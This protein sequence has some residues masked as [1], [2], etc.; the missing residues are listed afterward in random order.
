MKGVCEQSTRSKIEKKSVLIADNQTIIRE[1]IKYRIEKDQDFKIVGESASDRNV[2]EQV[3]Q[4]LPDILIFDF[5]E[6]LINGLRTIRQLKDHFNKVKI[7]VYTNIIDPNPVVKSLK[8]GTDGYVL[9]KSD[10]SVLIKGIHTILEGNSFID[11]SL[12]PLIISV[13][14]SFPTGKVIDD[15]KYNQLTE[16]ETE[17]FELVT[18]GKK[19]REI[20]ERLYISLKTVET[21]RYNIF[22][23]LSLS[24]VHELIDYAEKIGFDFYD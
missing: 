14:K 7:L 17:V 9:K 16:R 1:G 11:Y 2:I 24:T 18:K 20:A 4:T 22:K 19:S 10:S 8:A 15:P 6:N 23:K 3:K 13:V 21:H 5:P 12:L